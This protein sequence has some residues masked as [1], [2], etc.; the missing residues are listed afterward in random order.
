M[1][2]TSRYLIVQIFHTAVQFRALLSPTAEDALAHLF[3]HIEPSALSSILFCRPCNSILP[4]HIEVFLELLDHPH[5]L[6]T[7]VNFACQLYVVLSSLSTA[8]TT[9]TGC[10]QLIS[11]L[12]D[13]RLPYSSTALACSALDEAVNALSILIHGDELPPGRLRYSKPPYPILPI[14]KPVNGTKI[15]QQSDAKIFAFRSAICL[16]EL[17]LNLYRFCS[18]A[19]EERYSTNRCLNEGSLRY[20]VQACVKTVHISRSFEGPVLSAAAKLERGSLNVLSTMA[21]VGFPPDV[22]ESPFVDRDVMELILNEILSE[23]GCSPGSCDSAASILSFIMTDWRS[24]EILINNKL[25]G[26]LRKSLLKCGPEYSAQL[27]MW[28]GNCRQTRWLLA[29]GQEITMRVW[30]EILSRVEFWMSRGH[31]HYVLKWFGVLRILLG[32][33]SE[34][35]V[36]L[37]DLERVLIER[38]PGVTLEDWIEN[39]ARLIP[40]T[41]IECLDEI[42]SIRALCRGPSGASD[43]QVSTGT[44]AVEAT[45]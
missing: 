31:S 11:A 8:C 21:S 32:R 3:R 12:S 43:F 16:C 24:E 18:G 30:E 23:G 17:L 34:R 14:E 40:E 42:K 6:Y 39:L 22:T 7:D 35:R 28:D 36:A 9:P 33:S 37:I 1:C 13:L 38:E 15:L 45:G 5:L 20:M 4:S 44:I 26:S 19:F 41:E 27:Y 25:L 2:E 29:G 10:S